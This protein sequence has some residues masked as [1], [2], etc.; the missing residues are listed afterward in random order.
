MGKK[1][2]ITTKPEGGISN[3][4][5]FHLSVLDIVPPVGTDTLTQKRTQ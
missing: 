2:G 1:I 4:S 5:I 3:L